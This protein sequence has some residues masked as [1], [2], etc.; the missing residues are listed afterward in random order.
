M[1]HVRSSGVRPSTP[2]A[3]R[4]LKNQVVAVG[5]FVEVLVCMPTKPNQSS[6]SLPPTLP[7][8]S[9][10]PTPQQLLSFSEAC[11]VW[12][13]RNGLCSDVEQAG[14]QAHRLAVTMLRNA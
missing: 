3:L 7:F 4:H 8:L 2:N 10:S 1:A 6:S 13:R 5:P 11:R 9:P 12:V 14:A